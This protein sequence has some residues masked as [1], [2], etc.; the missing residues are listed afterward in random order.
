MKH[1]SR[2]S[3][4]RLAEVQMDDVIQVMGLLNALLGFYRDIADTF[5]FAI[6]QKGGQEEA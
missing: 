5:G 1:L 6:P 4:P 3:T 2:I